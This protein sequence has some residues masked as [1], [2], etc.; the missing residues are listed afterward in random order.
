MNLLK[1]IGAYSAEIQVTRVWLFLCIVAFVNADIML[2]T[3]DQL[4][5]G[6]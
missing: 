6:F 3:A 5:I 4:G 1:Y 2:C